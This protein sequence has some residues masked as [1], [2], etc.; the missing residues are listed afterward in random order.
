MN[1]F[2]SKNSTLSTV[3]M[4]VC[5]LLYSNTACM[6]AKT[7]VLVVTSS[8]NNNDSPRGYA[9]K[10]QFTATK[11]SASLLETPQFVSVI[12]REQM[13]T[14]P[15]ES[16]SQA[17]RY[18]AGVTSEKFGA[19]GNGIDFSKI[20]GFDADYYLD[21]LRVIGNSGIWGPQIDSW[22]L[23][24]IEAVH[25]PSSALYGQGGAGGVI[26]MQ[27][28]RPSVNESHQIQFQ[29]G[30]FDNDSIKFDTTGALNDSE[31]LLYRMDGLALSTDSQIN[32]SKQ[33]RYLLAPSLTWQPNEKLSLTVLSQYQRDPHIGHYNTL[34]AQAIGLL[35]NRNGKLDFTQNYSDPRHEQSERTQWSITSLIDYQITPFITF[36]QNIRYSDVDTHIKRDFT[37]GFL[38]G[39]QRLTAVYQDSPSHSKT[40]VADNQLIYQ[41]DTGPIRHQLLF[42]FDYQTGKLDKDWWGSQTV[43]FDPW[44]KP[45]HPEFRPYPVSRTSTTQ[46]FDRYGVYLQD[47]LSWQQWDLLLSGRYDWSY[48]NT[49][50]NLTN[51]TQK[52]DTSAWSQRVGLTYSFE[53]GFSPWVSVSD[54]FDPVLGTDAE[55]KPF[56]PTESKQT[57]LGIKYQNQSGDLMVSLAA[58]ELEQKNVTT[59]NPLNPDYYNQTGKIRSRGIDFESRFAITTSLNMM[60][61]YAYTD[62]KITQSQDLSVLN[63]HPVQVPKHSGSAW[64]DYRFHSP[65]LEGALVGVGVR[66]LGATWGDNTNTFKVPAVWLGDVSARYQMDALIPELTGMELGVTVSNITNNPYVASCTSSTYCSIGT[67]RTLFATLNYYF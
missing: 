54:S 32:S 14:L 67:N 10:T 51:T 39:D 16:I 28:R 37:R 42:G 26:N 48:L 55:G 29:K 52:N 1:N 33:S 30:N 36:K 7:D 24:S 2:V 4:L 31:T 57:E 46:R 45:H 21:G 64:V 9:N 12:K 3:S 59:H 43:S 53:S 60:L 58:Y 34:P 27:S 20:R 13:D 17:L 44:V 65:Y 23:N 49:D 15:S 62:N 25:G 38:A 63:K 5:T 40:W 47:Q 18:S 66:Y 56:I 11:G 8:E 19:F 22:T 61:N 6:A 35:P 41:L 50:N